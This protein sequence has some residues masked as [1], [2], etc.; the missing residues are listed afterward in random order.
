LAWRVGGTYGITPA[1]K[2]TFRPMQLMAD[3]GKEARNYMV[4]FMSQKGV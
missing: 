1:E 4:N 2:P 3:L